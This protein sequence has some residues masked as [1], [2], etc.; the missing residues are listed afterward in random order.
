MDIMDSYPAIN[1]FYIVMD[2]AHIHQSK[3][4]EESKM[5]R[6]NS[7]EEET[8]STRIKEACYLATPQNLSGSTKSSIGYFDLYLK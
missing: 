2:N 6:T 7:L 5:K 3:Q 4:I 1:N 8:F